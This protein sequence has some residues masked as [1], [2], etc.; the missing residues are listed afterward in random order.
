M[1][2]LLILIVV[3]VAVY[4]AWHLSD[5]EVRSVMLR[6]ITKHGMFLGAI[7]V[8]LLALIALANYL[9]SQPIL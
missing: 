5:A 8:V 7:L 1:K 2:H 6:Q 3:I 4:A 9:P